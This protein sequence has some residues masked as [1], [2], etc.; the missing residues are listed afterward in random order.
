MKI[1][2]FDGTVSFPSGEIRRVFNRAEFLR[3]PLGTQSKESFCNEEWRHY[4]IKPEPEIAGTV[5]FNGEKLLK[6]FLMMVI[7]SDGTDKWTIELEL[8]RKSLHERWLQKELG[9]P[10]WNYEW[11]RVVSEFDAKSVASEIIV[12]YDR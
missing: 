8:E 5:L 10:P 11:G 7:P 12:V 1:G 4:E 3:S 2:V 6:V 9:T